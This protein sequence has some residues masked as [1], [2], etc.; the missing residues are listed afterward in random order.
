M[1]DRPSRDGRTVASTGVDDEVK[2]RLREAYLNDE[3]R[4]L[5]VTAVRSAGDEVVVEFRLPH[6]E[7]T[8]LERFSVPKHGSL[9]DSTAFLSFLDA[10][11]V[12]PL[13]VDELVGVRVP[14]TYDAD[15][16]W[17]LDEAYVADS[18]VDETETVG[19]RRRLTGWLRTHRDWLLA[20]LLIAGEL[21]LVAVII[22][23]Y[24]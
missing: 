17:H 4:E 3:E 14:A 7:A 24:G 9:A 21:L 11:G 18:V 20:I 22:V 12:S 5:V 15:T 2:Q 8:H 19:P 23:V 10:A 1:S 6:G 13:D 16:G